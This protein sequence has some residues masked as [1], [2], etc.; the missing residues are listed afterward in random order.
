MGM[1]F[2]AGIAL[3]AA[4]A[5]DCSTGPGT[6]TPSATM[7][8]MSPASQFTLN[9]AAAIQASTVARADITKTTTTIKG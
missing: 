5:G 1:V 7:F 2:T 4:R 3:R 6:P 9:T 8:G